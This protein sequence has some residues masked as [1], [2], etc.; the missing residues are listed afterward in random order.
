MKSRTSGRSGAVGIDRT[1]P[2]RPRLGKS[3]LVV[4]TTST[5]AN[6]LKGYGSLPVKVNSTWQLFWKLSVYVSATFGGQPPIML[7]LATIL[8][9]ACIII[10]G[11]SKQSIFT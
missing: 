6:I 11:V 2:T 4:A 8:F 7:V 9:F 5:T 3:R 10:I 1:V